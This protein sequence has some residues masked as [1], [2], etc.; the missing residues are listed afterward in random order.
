MAF[1]RASQGGGESVDFNS[2][3][4]RTMQVAAGSSVEINLGYRPKMVVVFGAYGP[5]NY[6]QLCNVAMGDYCY[7]A[8]IT[9]NTGASGGFASD[10]LPNSTTN[11]VGKI[12]DTGFIMN[13]T[14]TTKT[15]AVL[16]LK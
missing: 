11:R 4:L 1:I 7:N 14:S 9:G 16:I 12:T 3:E 6:A 2:V 5:T 13:N 8:S 15:V 10:A